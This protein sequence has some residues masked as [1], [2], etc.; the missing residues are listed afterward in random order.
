[1]TFSIDTYF[2]DQYFNNRVCVV[3]SNIVEQQ[4]GYMLVL[5]L[6]SEMYSTGSSRTWIE[7][8]PIPQKAASPSFWTLLS[9]AMN[10]RY[11][12]PHKPTQLRNIHVYVDR[13]TLAHLF[14][15]AIG[16]DRHTCKPIGFSKGYRSILFQGYL[17]E[18]YSCSTRQMLR[19]E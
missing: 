8:P 15:W 5:V 17:I 19:V 12:Y 7:Y 14:R 13:H 18:Q 16:I 11:R 2:L 4:V 6:P 10:N 1:M 3:L 9:Q